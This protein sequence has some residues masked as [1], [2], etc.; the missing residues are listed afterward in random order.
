MTLNPIDIIFFLAFFVVVVGV[1]MDLT[2]SLD[3]R[4]VARQMRASLLR[5][6]N[7]PDF[8][9]AVTLSVEQVQALFTADSG[10]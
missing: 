1:S 10:P 4:P 8:D 7:R 6:V 2:S 5:Y 3:K 9:P